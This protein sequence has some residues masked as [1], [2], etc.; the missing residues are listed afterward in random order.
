M[1]NF[2][3]I[4]KRNSTKDEKELAVLRWNVLQL[5][6][7][8]ASQIENDILRACATN[9][10]EK[11]LET[12]TVFLALIEVEGVEKFQLAVPLTSEL[13]SSVEENIKSFSADVKNSQFVCE[14][15]I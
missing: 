9:M 8:G 1:Q 2:L 14:Y 15:D 6:R 7:N 4:S 10:L 12:H 13:L 5:L 11:Q 3:F